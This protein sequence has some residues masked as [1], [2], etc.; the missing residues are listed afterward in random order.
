MVRQ[1]PTALRPGKPPRRS[2]TAPARP[3]SVPRGSKR[4]EARAWVTNDRSLGAD[5]PEPSLLLVPVGRGLTGWV[6]EHG[7]TLVVADAAADPR[8]V[9]VR[10]IDGP[11]SMLLVPMSYEDT[12][13]GVIVLSKGGRGQFDE[14]DRTTISIFAGHAAQAIVNAE[15]AG[16]LQLQQAELEHQLASQR[17]LLDVNERLLST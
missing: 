14:I 8:G 10:T 6:A 17:R 16:R 13:R 5:A 9:T 4:V 3:G 12:V 7:E 11:E 15:N 1:R 2:A